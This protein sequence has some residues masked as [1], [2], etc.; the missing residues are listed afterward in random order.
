MSENLETIPTDQ[1]GDATITKLTDEWASFY[2]VMG[3]I[4]FVII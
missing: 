2:L 3:G 4:L 1:V